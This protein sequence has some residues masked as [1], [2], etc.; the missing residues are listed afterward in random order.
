MVCQIVHFR[1][2]LL[3]NGAVVRFSLQQG[4]AETVPVSRGGRLNL[5][6]CLCFGDPLESRYD[7][8]VGTGSAVCRFVE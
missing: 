8:T 5:L 7:R 4:K 1:L 6:R 3:Y 2:S